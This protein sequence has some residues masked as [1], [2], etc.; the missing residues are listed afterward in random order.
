MN[1]QRKTTILLSVI[2]FIIFLVMIANISFNF[3]NYGIKSVEDKALVVSELIKHSLTS[4]MVNGTIDK[5]DF[6]LDQIKNS[7]QIKELWLVR[8]PSLIKQYGSGFANENARDEIDTEVIASGNS[9]RVVR[10]DIFF[11]NTFRMTIPYKA[12]VDEKINC[13]KCHDAKEGDTLGAISIIIDINDI[14]TIGLQTVM[15]IA[16][17]AFTVL[18]LIQ[19]LT[20]KLLKPYMVIFES[21]KQVVTKANSGDYS[22]RV[23]EIGSK[24]SIEVA[25]LINILMEKFENI[26]DEIEKKI[27]IFLSHKKVIKSQDPLEDVKST[28]SQLSDIYKFRRTIEHDR[29]IED[30]YNRIVTVFINKLAIKNFTI[31]ECNTTTK[32]TKVIYTNERLHCR[33][34][35]DGCRA[36]RA[37]VTVDSCQFKGICKS[38]NQNEESEKFYICL[39]YSISNDFDIIISIVTDTQ[40]EYARIHTIIHFIDDYIDSAK[41]EF[42]SKKLMHQLQEQSR[43]DP[44]TNLYNRKYLEEFIDEA[45]VEYQEY[46]TRYGVLMAD[47]DYFK[48]I[49]DKYGHSVGDDALKVIA[50]VLIDNATSKDL[51]ARYGG[52]EF[53][54]ILKDCDNER[55]LE[56]AQKIRTQ[57]AKQKI[58]TATGST[59]TKTISIGGALLPDNATNFWKVI[60]LADVALYDAKN[61]G[62]D[63]VEIF[64]KDKQ[65]DENFD[66][67]Y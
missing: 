23:K 2:F 6:F 19:I 67:A 1:A 26:L 28:I 21:M 39:P 57:F 41:T 42:V 5:R 32:S 15:D 36:D 62:R 51:V 13:L 25:K 31:I 33:V 40:E 4:H 54:V 45:M 3:R 11:H 14:K 24:E 66:I 55:L 8:S 47:I 10:E 17:V 63:R 34:E 16:L 44:L 58:K 29:S 65:R 53:I 38:F 61:G 60:K 12:T 37:S 22:G 43:R 46:G 18:I 56:V 59:F 7:A 9:K 27:D 48:M 64:D 35:S 20:G 49:N 50:K 30:I 52:E